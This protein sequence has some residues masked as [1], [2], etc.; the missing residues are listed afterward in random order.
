MQ[1]FM[2][3]FQLFNDLLIQSDYY[4]YGYGLFVPQVNINK[5]SNLNATQLNSLLAY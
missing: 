4:N 1:S 5:M 2:T 3:S